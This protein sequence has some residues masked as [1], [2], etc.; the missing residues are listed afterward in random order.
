[1]F[2]LR[3]IRLIILWLFKPKNDILADY[4]LNLRA[5]PIIDVDVTRMMVHAITR[6][7][8]LGRYQLVFGSEFRNFAFKH[9]WFPATV[10]EITQI[11][12]SIPIFSKITISS[13]IICWNDRRFYAEQKILVGN[14]VHVRS[15][16]EGV[17]GGPNGFMNPITVFSALGVHRDSPP[18][19]QEIESW[20]E[21]R[22]KRT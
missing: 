17:M 11:Y 5:W 20:V 4:R 3:L 10:A 6:A 14:Q 18:I 1:M 12:K 19:S 13:K 7:L 8:A 15:L 21:H 16:I 22:P 2:R 9:R